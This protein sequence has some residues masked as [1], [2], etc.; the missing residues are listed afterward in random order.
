M[1]NQST[2]NETY[3]VVKYDAGLKLSLKALTADFRH[4]SIAEDVLLIY[5]SKYIEEKKKNGGE[6]YA[7]RNTL[8]N[9]RSLGY[10][11]EDHMNKLI[12]AIEYAISQNFLLI[13]R[14][15]EQYTQILNML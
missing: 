8:G 2:T 14:D 13:L 4:L 6:F 12:N 1:D 5:Y 11:T 9:F 3:N 15:R 10:L 7:E